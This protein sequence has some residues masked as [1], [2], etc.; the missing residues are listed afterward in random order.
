MAS[1]EA[2]MNGSE[3]V[4]TTLSG[5]ARV[6]DIKGHPRGELRGLTKIVKITEDVRKY[7]AEH[8]MSEEAAL[9]EGLKQK[10]TEFNEAGAEIYAKA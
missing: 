8:G 5:S 6:N 4:N 7:A 3:R 9:E 10:S 1:R 2:E